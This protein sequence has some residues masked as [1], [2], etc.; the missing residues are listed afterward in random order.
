MTE[1]YDEEL[2][3][4]REDPNFPDRPQHPDFWKMAAVI[5][6]NDR[7]SDLGTEHRSGLAATIQV[8]VESLGYMAKNRAMRAQELL[9]HRDDGVP[10]PERDRLIMMWI[11]AFTA[12]MRFAQ[13]EADGRPIQPDGNR[14]ARRAKK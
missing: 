7:I 14:R 6:Q 8:D 4:P 11:D 10:I 2:M 13:I 9:S 5:K 3:E 12:G 1:N